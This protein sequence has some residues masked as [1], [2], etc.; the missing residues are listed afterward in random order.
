MAANPYTPVTRSNRFYSEMDYQYE[1]DLMLEYVESDLNQA[2][3]VYNVD[4]S[5][6]NLNAVY[7]ETR[8]NGV[9]FKPPVEVPCLYEIK[10]AE[11]KSYDG[12]TSNAAYTISG[13]LTVWVL[14]KAL[15]K[16]KVDINRG[17]YIGVMVQPGQMVYFVVT[18]DG[19]VNTSN[20]MVIGAYRAASRVITAAPVDESEFSGK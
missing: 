10:P 2:V 16:Y 17:D 3:V 11:L 7:K 18:N 4:R 1:T 14:L 8:T 9:R 6:T 20:D 12:K 15:T 19:K 5:K 13:P